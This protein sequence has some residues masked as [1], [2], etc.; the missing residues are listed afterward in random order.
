MSVVSG[1]VCDLC[2]SAVHDNNRLN[3][4][5]FNVHP[6]EHNAEKYGC[7]VCREGLDEA[8]PLQKHMEQIVS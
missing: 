2:G 7:D 5:R 8:E 6:I 1:V 4:H 3:N